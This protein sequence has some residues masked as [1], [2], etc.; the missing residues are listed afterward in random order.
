MGLWIDGSIDAIG[1]RR[2][3]D[4]PVADFRIVAGIF[5]ERAD[6]L[7]REIDTEAFTKKIK[8]W[9]WQWVNRRKDYPITP[10]G[11][12]ITIATRLYKKY[13]ERINNAD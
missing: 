8:Q 11:N 12:P 9:E 10:S 13:L 7:C 4:G 6:I 2:A 5:R 1:Q 3:I